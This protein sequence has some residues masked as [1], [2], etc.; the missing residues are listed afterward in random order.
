MFYKE[1]VLKNWGEFA[2]LESHSP[3]PIASSPH[4][5]R[6]TALYEFNRTVDVNVAI[7]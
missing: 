3:T 1:A 6:H 5:H 4:K 2:V 7:Q